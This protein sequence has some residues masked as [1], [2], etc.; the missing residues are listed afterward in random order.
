MRHERPP[1]IPPTPMKNADKFRPV[2]VR[3]SAVLIAGLIGWVS[4]LECSGGLARSAGSGF[5]RLA[6]AQLVEHARLAKGTETSSQFASA[7]ELFQE[8]MAMIREH[9][10]GD[11]PDKTLFDS[12]L[13]ELTLTML[14]HCA[15]ALTLPDQC[16]ENAEQCFLEAIHF[17]IARCDLE[18]R[19]VILKALRILLHKLDGNSELLDSQMLQE[20]KISTSGRFGGIGM[21]VGIKDGQYTVIA[22]FE[23]SPAYRAGI[24]AGDSVLDI[25]GKPV[26]KLTLH[27]VLAKVRGSPGSSITLAVRPRGATTVREIT[28]RRRVIRISPVR[29]VIL[30][31]G[32]GYLRI[33]NFQQNTAAEVARTLGRMF[34]SVRGGLKGLIVD[35][36]DNPGGLF[37]QGIAVADLFLSGEPITVVRGRH[38]KMNM[39]YTASPKTALLRVPTVLLINHGTASAAEVLVGA[40]QGKPGVLIMGERSFGKASVQGI[41]SLR[42]GIALRLT[43][44]YYYT[45]DGRDI[46]GKG[47]EPDIAL[48]QTAQADE[49][50]KPQPVSKSDLEKDSEVKHAL[51]Y[52]VAE[53][54]SGKPAFQSYY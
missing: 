3:A 15:A 43:T 16:S 19:P 29:H 1:S 10:A 33:V 20:V 12:V 49:G 28:L 37:D 5:N 46:D 30:D 27:E 42:K 13:G 40:L 38:R 39:D 54:S 31:G 21:L 7:A 47:I 9:F 2:V 6:Q 44:G 26:E 23:G 11:P 48:D 50:I 22:S 35:L 52:L 17:S 18:A 45:A 36:R 4:P 14:P 25:D 32:V 34:V 51:E 8:T 53:R 41:Y 24:R